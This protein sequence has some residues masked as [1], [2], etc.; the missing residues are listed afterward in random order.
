MLESLE[1]RDLPSSVLMQS[2]PAQPGVGLSVANVQ[3]LNHPRTSRSGLRSAANP[4]HKSSPDGLLG[5]RPPGPFLK[6]NVIQHYAD[7]LYGPSSPTPMTPTPRE[8]HRETITG[9]WIGQYSIGPPRFSDRASTIHA[10]S[11][12]GGSNQFFKGKLDMAI[13]P[14]ADPSAVS[15]PGN[16]YANQVIGVVGLFNQNLL[17]SGGV[18]V[19]DLNGATGPGS[20]PL[21]LPTR[22]GWTYDSNTS[23]GPYAAPQ[24]FLQGAGTMDL[25]WVPDSHALPGTMGSGRVIITF[26]GLINASQLVSAVSKFIS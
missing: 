10:W 23:A 22:L 5:K 17:Q 20:R 3:A 2:E 21:A 14:P 1:V 12:T 19:L 13:F 6:P 25:K 8:I 26:Q 11:R 9:R 24:Q 18:L 15:T 7:L 16:P 4:A